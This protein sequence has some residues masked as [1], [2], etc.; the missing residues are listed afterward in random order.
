MISYP[1]EIDEIIEHALAAYNQ[2]NFQLAAELS[3]KVIQ[4]YPKHI[5][6]LEIIS[7]IMVQVG[8]MDVA[9]RIT[10][11]I[12]KEYSDNCNAFANLANLYF[13]EN[14]VDD[15]IA[16][17][18]KAIILNKNDSN[19]FKTL[20]N[21]LLVKGNL[22]EA[23]ENHQESYSLDPEF[24]PQ[25]ETLCDI[26]YGK[27]KTLFPKYLEKLYQASKHPI[28]KI[29]YKTQILPYYNSQEEIDKAR[30]TLNK[31]L[32]KLITEDFI[33]NDIKTKV[34]LS[35]FYLANH[36]KNNRELREKFALMFRKKLP[37]INYIAEHCKPDAEKKPAESKTKVG[38][39]SNN[40]Y[41]IHPV[42]KCFNGIIERLAEKDDLEIIIFF[43]NEGMDKHKN[44]KSI[45]RLVSSADKFIPLNQNIDEIKNIIEAE[46]LDYLVYTDIGMYW[47]TY[48]LAFMRLAPVQCLIPGHP[49]TSGID[50]IDYYISSDNLEGEKAQDYYSEKLIQ[51]NKIITFHNFPNLS[52]NFKSRTELNLP[53]NKTIY[54]CPMKGQKL[55]PDFDEVFV[56]ILRQDE[57][58]VILIPQDDGELPK[59]IRNRIEKLFGTPLN[60]RLVMHSWADNDTFYSYLK[61]SDVILD[62][63]PFGAGTT[64]Y[65]AFAIDAPIITMPAETSINR[66]TY[67]CYKQM[68]IPCDNLVAASF[69]D[70]VKKAINLANN[71]EENEKVR[72][73]IS[74]NKAKLFANPQIV[75]EFAEFFRGKR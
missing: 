46:K 52:G 59:L 44:D 57:N 35:I 62:S 45:N 34:Y 66:I 19:Y 5:S 67:A 49:E 31:N 41:E 27:D 55:H 39:I 8:K 75:E 63:Y 20:G 72:K 10:E 24:I 56:K 16:A 2:K 47:L 60:D 68:G 21:F 70:Y 43:I 6:A 64:T 51:F 69:D 36:N 61:I 23:L 4:L 29:C 18:K 17:I 53:Q 25:L 30:D 71:K 54:Y 22:K 32:D 74:E 50:T 9:T 38:F 33:I 37:Q 40:L 73:L 3:N 65:F 12:T 11:A 1:K 7:M 15:A 58:S 14:R 42:A 13:A 26:T 48:F 28:L